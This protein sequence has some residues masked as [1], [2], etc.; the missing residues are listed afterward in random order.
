M[1]EL[2]CLAGHRYLES[3]K[4]HWEGRAGPLGP[5]NCRVVIISRVQTAHTLIPD[6]GYHFP[7][8]FPTFRAAL[9]YA[10]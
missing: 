10:Q 3:D 1:A 9:H 7:D 5:T 6:Q 2:G 8:L 4:D